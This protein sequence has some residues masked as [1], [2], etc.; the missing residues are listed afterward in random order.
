MYIRLLLANLIVKFVPNR[1]DGWVM[2]EWL[3]RCPPCWVAE[4]SPRD[5]ALMVLKPHTITWR[6][7]LGI[8]ICAAAS[9]RRL[10]PMSPPYKK[11]YLSAR[12]KQSNGE[13]S[14]PGWLAVVSCVLFCL[15]GANL[16]LLL[17]FL[18]LF[19]FF[20][21]CVGGGGGGGGGCIVH[22]RMVS[23][24]TTAAC[25]EKVRLRPKCL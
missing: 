24:L 22:G 25:G 19:F 10:V 5:L 21:V 3:A 18:F 20:L 4:R 12:W 13:I 16:F 23:T 11:W 6:N 2:G 14:R 17:S 7:Y 15:A 8:G 1:F 9:A